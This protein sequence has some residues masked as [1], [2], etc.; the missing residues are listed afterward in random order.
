MT[1]F[2]TDDPSSKAVYDWLN[3]DA[4][5]RL[6]ADSIERSTYS[7]TEYH[8]KSQT[9]VDYLDYVE[10][11]QWAS[12]SEVTELT[13]SFIFAMSNRSQKVDC[14]CKLRSHVLTTSQNPLEGDVIIDVPATMIF[15]KCWYKS[16]RRFISN[17]TTELEVK[18]LLLPD[19][20][21]RNITRIAQWKLTDGENAP[22]LLPFEVFKQVWWTNNVSERKATTKQIIDRLS[23]VDQIHIVEEK[24]RETKHKTSSVLKRVLLHFPESDHGLHTLRRAMG[25]NFSNVLGFINK[26]RRALD[27]TTRKLTL[28]M[29]LIKE[30]KCDFCLEEKFQPKLSIPGIYYAPPGAGK[31]T[32]LDH[33]KLVALDTDW[34]GVGLT[35]MDYGPMLKLGIPIIT[36]Q[37]TIFKSSGFKVIGVVKDKIRCDDRGVPLGKA[38]EIMEYQKHYPQDFLFRKISDKEHVSDWI[39]WMQTM[40]L[41]QR[42]TASYAINQLPFYKNESSEE[43]SRL[44]PKLLRNDKKVV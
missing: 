32:A 29:I 5:T 22:H 24:Q 11:W 1:E 17:I 41:I 25:A 27:T 3:E 35:W 20:V 15:G 36:N 6:D 4:R 39:G 23:S 8:H 14:D 10:E 21:D 13:Q 16:I 2:E 37:Y 19:I 9:Y 44:F 38:S 26:N 42:R 18:D 40:A 34:L 33:G 28:E 31:T 7:R 43:W 12:T 30:T